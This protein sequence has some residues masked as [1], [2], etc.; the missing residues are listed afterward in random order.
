MQDYINW[1]VVKKICAYNGTISLYS[2]ICVKDGNGKMM[3][4][5]S[6]ESSIGNK[7]KREMNLTCAMNC[8]W[9]HTLDM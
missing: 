3:I 7:C 5:L 9:K 6:K 4:W 1:K 2:V 8:G